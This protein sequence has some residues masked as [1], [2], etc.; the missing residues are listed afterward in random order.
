MLN[1]GL[2]ACLSVRLSVSTIRSKHTESIDLNMAGTI[3]FS[4]AKAQI[5]DFTIGIF[6]FWRFTQTSAPRFDGPIDT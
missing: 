6:F 1:K 2:S 4:P 5:K 3:A